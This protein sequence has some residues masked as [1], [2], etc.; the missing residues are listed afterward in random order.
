MQRV[1]LGRP[2]SDQFELIRWED[3]FYT[4]DSTFQDQI[5]SPADCEMVI[6]I[7][8]KRLGSDLPDE[9]RR[10][11]GTLPTGTE[12]EFEMAL[13]H[14]AKTPERT[15]DILVYRKTEEVFFS[16][17]QL[18]VEQQQ[19][20]RFLTFWQRW[21]RNEK[22]HFVAGFHSFPSTAEFETLVEAHLRRWLSE[23]HGE[24]V[25]TKGSPFRGLEPF[26]VDHAEIF[27][28]RRR[29]TD[30][31]RAR[32]L[33][34]A[35]AGCR[36]LLIQ[37]ASGS[38]K[39]SLARAGV[40]PQLL[41]AGGFGEL[42]LMDRYAITSPAALRMPDAGNDWAVGLAKALFAKTAL[43]GELAEGDFKSP[44]TLAPLLRAEGAPAVTPLI[45]A[46]DRSAETDQVSHL[47]RG[48][49]LLVDQFEELFD[50]PAEEAEA[51]L[52][53]LKMA[54]DSGQIF[55]LATMRS[56]F[57][58][59]IGSL[60][61]F[62]NLTGLHEVRG[63]DTPDPIVALEP[64]GPADIRDIINGPAKAAGLTFE[65]G[66]DGAPD[67]A[68]R[69]EASAEPDALPALQLLLT[70]LY[71]RKE[72]TLLT[73]AAFDDVGG[74]TGVMA[75][76]GDEVL[77]SAP[78]N[79]A[80][81]FTKIVR[82]FVRVDAGDAPA[83]ARRVATSRFDADPPAQALCERLQNAGL[84][85]A[86]A[87][88]M[89]LAHESLLQGWQ[90]LKQAVD[91]E[92][93]FFEIRA[94]LGPLSDN[95]QRQKK[96]DPGKAK[97]ALLTGLNLLEGE[98]LLKTWGPEQVSATN[99]DLP[100]LITTSSQNAKR[101]RRRRTTLIGAAT[102]AV[103]AVAIG[104][105]WQEVR[106]TQQALETRL[107]ASMAEAAQYAL[108]TGD[109]GRALISATQALAVKETP[110]TRSMAWTAANEHS[111]SQLSAL[112]LGDLI[113]IDHASDGTTAR[114]LLDGRLELE[115]G[116][117]I[118]RH[119]LP[120]I[121]ETGRFFRAVRLLPDHVLLITS[122]G[123][124]GVMRWFGATELQSEIRWLSDTRYFPSSR[125]QIETAVSQTGF[126]VA[127]GD[128]SGTPPL[129]LSCSFEIVCSQHALPADIVSTMAFDKSG[130][131]LAIVTADRLL[132]Y[133]LD[134]DQVV[135]RADL[136]FPQYT[137]KSISWLD[138][139]RVSV[140]HLSGGISILGW[141]PES[142]EINIRTAAPAMVQTVSPYSDHHAYACL[143]NSICV[144]TPNA[145]ETTRPRVL[146]RLNSAVLDLDWGP[147]GSLISI[148][149][150]G[151]LA[152]WDV[153]LNDGLVRQIPISTKAITALAVIDN[154]RVAAGDAAGQL[155]SI[156]VTNTQPLAILDGDRG[157]VVHIAN[158]Q[159]GD[160]AAAFKFGS[161]ARMPGAGGPP[162]RAD[163]TTLP[164]RLAWLDQ[165]Q[166]LAA[167]AAQAITF[168]PLGAEPT[169]PAFPLPDGTTTIGAVVDLSPR[170]MRYGYSL[171]NGAIM[172]VDSTGQ[173]SALV[174]LTQSADRLSAL[175]LDLS[176]NG[177]WL[178]ASRSDDEVR[179]F[180]LDQQI[181]PISLKLSSDDSK[182]ARFSPSGDR[183]GVLGSDGQ[184][185]IWSFDPATGQAELFM[186][187][188]PVSK[189]F[190]PNTDA[191]R[192]AQWFDWVDDQQ[193]AVATVVGD[194]LLIDLSWQNMAGYVADK[195]RLIQK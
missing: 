55:V 190:A 101:K 68:A 120:D 51:F 146:Y 36:F 174:P 92:R 58:H 171:S 34:N 126:R 99:P 112:I 176:P 149:A 88:G 148:Q 49:I 9:Y 167:S 18:A 15:P 125:H 121:A 44:E 59:K 6:C 184:L 170:G 20:E 103:V 52:K 29:E 23:Q 157:D 124:V 133:N 129:I 83:L 66:T 136:P 173:H 25:W 5:D 178:I 192:A 143:T 12:Y 175:S 87:N 132:R 42:P 75:F 40:L 62:A 67:L 72:D 28:G 37:G 172:A 130:E 115:A 134:S 119:Q 142:Q 162:L 4:A 152:Y 86:D 147:D 127:I 105:T 189:G 89:R 79:Q 21:F 159:N 35:L 26:D 32:F 39:S 80:Q 108:Q 104:V 16:E 64:P 11:D 65:G 194:V 46:L 177:R 158:G 185:S 70:Q 182:V 186:R 8:W 50:W 57:Q 153:A 91:D 61:T 195:L 191:S 138:D 19:R 128:E 151:S 90:A 145:S 139:E 96:D 111:S 24:V 84:I 179:V 156:D 116:Q 166:T 169:T 102:L 47:R 135:M 144:T 48:C 38:G 85:T 140:G 163:L 31:T 14:A 27:F 2:A 118:Q 77:A 164:E 150:D 109:W 71:D 69:I 100:E 97:E 180:D 154:G 1:N 82:S 107:Q 188:D 110:D 131:N 165:G 17:E 114:L 7:F 95:Y 22:G 93:H 117:E 187:V 53:W 73:H 3:D 13:H 168:W 63:P 10:D 123:W 45:G 113:D 106:R 41:S 74:V 56:E 43:G 60:K 98:S 193:V 81:A 78:K 122:D 161:V 76:L 183:V 54:M 141:G 94:R 33:A 137:A 30:R 155:Y 181:E 160:W